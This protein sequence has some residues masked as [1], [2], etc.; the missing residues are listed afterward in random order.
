MVTSVLQ[1]FTEKYT[2]FV[3][4]KMLRHNLGCYFVNPKPK[5]KVHVGPTF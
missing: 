3:G 1:A 4:R 5:S 2:S